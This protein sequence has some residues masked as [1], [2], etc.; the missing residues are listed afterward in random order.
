[1][2]QENK[3]K[4]KT[5]KVLLISFLIILVVSLIVGIFVFTHSDE[6]KP[7][8][9]VSE[10]ESSQIQNVDLNA[11]IT[12]RSSAVKG[13]KEGEKDDKK[14]LVETKTVA[15]NSKVVSS[16]KPQKIEDKVYSGDDFIRL[17]E[18]ILP[19][20]E[21]VTFDNSPVIITGNIGV[22]KVIV[23]LAEKRGYKKRPESN[24]KSLSP[25]MIEAVSGL[26]SEA[27]K[28]GLNLTTVSSFRSIEDQKNIFNNEL[29][30]L[31]LSNSDI[32]ARKVDDQIESIMETRSIPGYSKHHTGYTVDFGCNS[33]DLLGFKNTEC[34][35]WIEK[36]NFEKAKKFGIIPSYPESTIKQGPNPEEW[37]FV[38]VGV[39][40][41]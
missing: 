21:G 10:S 4:K 37:E 11:E 39:E 22:D 24:S 31:G 35:N 8:D 18:S 7:E 1:M 9:K 19:N 41:I 30:A 2:Y 14:E 36:N 15:N 27:K 38:W 13:V 28:A 17:Y 23:D 3:P 5:K 33:N 12:P 25:K 29:K 34:Y 6:Q 26:K 40:N 32:I 20:Y 16:A